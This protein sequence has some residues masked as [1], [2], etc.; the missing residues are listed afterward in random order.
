MNKPMTDKFTKGSFESDPHND[1]LFHAKFGSEGSQ[2]QIVK[3]CIVLDEVM[4]VVAQSTDG[5][6]ELLKIDGQ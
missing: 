4:Y 3:T 6:V 1:R 5:E 2:Q